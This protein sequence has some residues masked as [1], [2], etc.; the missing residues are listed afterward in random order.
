MT[1]RWVLKSGITKA[2][3]KLMLRDGDHYPEK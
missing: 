1:D 3:K 2:T